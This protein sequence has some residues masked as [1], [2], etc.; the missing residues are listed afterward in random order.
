MMGG[1]STYGDIKIPSGTQ[2]QIPTTTRPYLLLNMVESADGKT[3]IEGKA[4]RLGTDIDRDV[5]RTLRSRADA[6]MVGGGT[7]RAERLSLSLDA[8]DTRPVPRAVKR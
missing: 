5:M 2:A 8:E 6:V 4:S 3:D 1:D 7:I